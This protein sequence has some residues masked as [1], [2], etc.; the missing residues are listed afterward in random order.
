MR[1]QKDEKENEDYESVNIDKKKIGII[2]EKMLFRLR[3]GWSVKECLI[4]RSYE[5]EVIQ[6]TGK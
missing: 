2:V 5:G 4:I 3:R 1:I 6:T